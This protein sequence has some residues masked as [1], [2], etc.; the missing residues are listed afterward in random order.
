[1][2]TKRD[3]LQGG[4]N[5]CA[6]EGALV[7]GEAGDALE[8]LELGQVGRPPARQGFHGGALQDAVLPAAVPR[9][10]HIR[11]LLQRYPRHLPRR[12]LL[13]QRRQLLS[14]AGD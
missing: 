12:H 2:S 10:Q 4:N 11:Q 5:V 7:F 9:P 3:L 6:V 14:R 13:L 8:S 1:M